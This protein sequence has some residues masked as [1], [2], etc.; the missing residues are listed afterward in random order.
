MS[1]TV[2]DIPQTNPARSIWRTVLALTLIALALRAYCCTNLA[3]ISRDGVQFTT[4]AKQLAEDPIATM[5]ATTKQPGFSY[6]LLGTHALLG[7]TLD[8]TEPLAWERCGQLLALIG[9]VAVCPLI[10]LLTLRLFDR[11]TA[12]L[13]ALLTAC[14]PA[15]AH[16]S[17]DVLSDM[18]H[19]ALYLAAILL[20]YRGIRKDK[21]ALLAASGIVAG[22]AY[23]IR[24]EALVLMPAIAVCWMWPGLGTGTGANRKLQRRLLGTALFVACF[25]VIL[26]PHAFATGRLMPNKT[27]WELLFGTQAAS[28]CRSMGLMLAHAIPWHKAPGRMAEEWARS[29]RYVVSTLVLLGLFLKTAPRAESTGRRLV[30]VTVLLHLLAVQ[31]RVKSYGEISSRYLVVPFILSVPWA[32]TGFITFLSLLSYRIDPTKPGRLVALLLGGG[33]AVLFPLFYYA[34]LPIHDGKQPLRTAGQWLYEN[35]DHDDIVLAHDRLEQSLFYA[36]R[37]FPHDRWRSFAHVEPTETIGKI[38]KTTDA[39]WYLDAT[40]ART[41]KGRIN[42]ESPSRSLLA[43]EMPELTP[44]WSS[45]PGESEAHIFRV[46]HANTRPQPQPES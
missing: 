21:I 31:L 35:A 19:L 5:K 2:T 7:S 6:L 22:I 45:P 42:K 25:C 15:G 30:I 14:W 36:D 4:Y 3:C 13:A 37:T 16:L 27:P 32:A 1:K 17:A 23:L 38:V 20:A 44:A 24:Q 43:S 41:R 8:E 12:I 33:F 40:V 29:G 11:F 28:S 39:D 9:G 34:T 26:S 46:K 10:Y 18:P